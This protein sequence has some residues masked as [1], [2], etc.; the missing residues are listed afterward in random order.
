MLRYNHWKWQ[1]IFLVMVIAEAGSLSAQGV[2]LRIETETGVTQFRMGE[3]ID[4]TLTFETSSPDTWMVRITGKD[5]SVLGLERDGFP[6]SPAEGTSDP[7]RYRFGGPVAYSGPG[8]MF[9]H[10]KTTVAHVDLN[11][12]VRFER[13]GYYRV[14]GLFHAGPSPLRGVDQPGADQNVTLESNEIGIEIVAAD[15]EWQKRQLREDVAVLNVVPVKTDNETFE[16]RMDAARR[17][18]YLDTADSVREAGRLLGTADVQVGQI[19]QTGL[20]VSGRRDE[21][22]AAMKQLLRSPDQ[23]VTPMFLETLTELEAWQR[24]PQSQDLRSGPGWQRRYEA[25]VSIAGQLRSELAEVVEQKRNSAKAIS[26]KTLLDNMPPEAAPAALRLEIAHLFLELPSGQQS[27]LVNSQWKKI[28]GPEMIPVL[29]QIYDAAPETAGPP[30]PMVATAVERLYELD[31]AQ[32]R[33]LILDEMRR[34]VPRLPFETLAILPDAALPEMDQLL[35]DHLENNV[36]TEELIARYATPGIL[37]RVKA[38]Y[39]KRDAMM[40]ARTS[41]GVPDLA[42]PACEPPL[43]AYFLRADPAWGERVLRE[44]LAERSYPGGRCWMTILGRT[45]AYYVSPEWEKIAVL[46]LHDDTVIVKADAVKALGQHGSAASEA[47][48][49]D[50]FRYWHGWWK[51]KRAEMNEE[52]RRFEQV[53]LESIAHAR[54]WDITAGDLEKVRALCVTP[55]CSGRAEEYRREWK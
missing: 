38:F 53:F 30:R 18:W 25:H 12:W 51:D 40:R 27:E 13:P 2:S 14:H 55:D 43:V 39:A 17:I 46:A 24:I 16:A 11:Q 42:S 29:R 35:A 26:M 36:G 1:L 28:A 8:G 3:A 52:N 20:Q 10:E 44:S 15:A 21:A 5:R 31:P 6:T 32:G 50:T 9:L 33:A 45:A 48:V 19:L 47:A 4:L 7:M 34:P 22:V 23:P 54:N 37:E 41:P 49:W